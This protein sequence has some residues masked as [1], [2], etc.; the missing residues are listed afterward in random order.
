MTQAT[1]YVVEKNGAAALG[2]SP[3]VPAFRQK[4]STLKVN[5]NP[6]ACPFDLGDGE[7]LREV[8]YQ[9]VTPLAYQEVEHT[10][11]NSVDG[12]GFWVIGRE[13]ENINLPAAKAEAKAKATENFKTAR[14][15]GMTA[16][17]GQTKIEVNTSTEAWTEIN[18][19]LEVTGG[20]SSVKFVTRAGMSVLANNSEVQAMKS[21][22]KDHR[23]AAQVN[24]YD[25]YA[26]IDA[27]ADLTE[28]R[29]IDLDSG[30]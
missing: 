22:V 18:A 27:A 9:A 20:G 17:I 16:T 13:A 10:G 28:L 7:T 2:P 1:R 6:P 15:G 19:A 29:A 8:K 21:A 3:W 23:Q 14:D 11:Q 4:R 12:D 25:L 5:K 26:A 24:E 30:W